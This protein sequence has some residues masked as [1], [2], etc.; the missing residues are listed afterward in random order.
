M[1]NI[2]NSL[3]FAMSTIY[4]YNSFALKLVY[5]S[6]RNKVKTEDPESQRLFKAS[7]S[8]EEKKRLEWVH[9]TYD[10]LSFIEI[11]IVTPLGAE[12]IIDQ[13]FDKL[14]F[15]IIVILMETLGLILASTYYLYLHPW[16]NINPRYAIYQKIHAMFCLVFIVSFLIVII[17]YSS[18][19][20]KMFA[21]SLLCTLI[22]AIT[23]KILGEFNKKL[24]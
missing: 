12:F 10:T 15:T 18:S 3:A 14:Y 23:I 4:T 16:K 8:Q 22:L 6:R 7:N 2:P 17:V 5:Q 19:A 11:C 9:I 13:N 1:A 24:K 21:L 20:V